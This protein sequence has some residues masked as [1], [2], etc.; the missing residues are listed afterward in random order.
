MNLFWEPG[1]ND[2][3]KS[4]HLF[5]IEIRD[6][7]LLEQE[8]PTLKGKLSGGT[9]TVEQYIYD[10]SV[11][12]SKKSAV[13][14]W[15]YKKKNTNGMEILH[16]C[17]FCNGEVLYATENDPELA[18]RGLYDHGEYPFVFDTLFNVEGTPA[19]LG[20]IDL[21]KDPQL[22][23]DKL[24]Q[25]I[26]K[27]AD[28]ACRL[29]WL[30]SGSGKVNEAEYADHT[31][32]FVHV[33]GV[34]DV[35]N[36][37]KQ[38]KVDPLPE[39]YVSI[40]NNTI[41]ELKETTGNRDF[42]QGGTSRGVTAASAIAALQEAGSKLSRDMIKSSY[43][44]FTQVCYFVI[45][46][47]RQFYTEPR[48]FRI[49]G[50]QGNTEFVTYTNQNIAMQTGGEEF[51][52]DI[53]YRKPIFDIKVTSQKSS[54]FSTVA[55]NERA[56]ELYGMGFFRP[57]MADQALAALDMMDF[58]G[59][60]KVRQRVSENGTLMQM[61]QQLQQQMMMMAQIIDSQNGTS[62]AP[63]LMAPQQQEGTPVEGSKQTIETNA[64]GDTFKQARDSTAGAA[65]TRA[66]ASATP[67]V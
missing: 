22:R 31:K 35:E 38:I 3:Q 2:I 28:I 1:I 58:E 50:E 64:L 20:Y 34:A 63:Q 30:I 61:V 25:V 41:E 57:D 37:L 32:E 8:Y 59:I 6:N 40:L 60:D 18:E 19:G 26:L 43:R 33:D 11:D 67:R 24:N 53:G 4:K 39:I 15:Y 55:Q 56:K 9:I 51:G 47:I 45:E 13:V 10:D 17:K 29:R 27:N 42:S 5:N 66:A 62:M 23:I 48:C 52:L 16:F 46:L 21:C 14:D 54:P 7:E 36:S 12:T 44:A 49:T 65:R